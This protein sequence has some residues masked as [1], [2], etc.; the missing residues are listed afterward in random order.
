M[1]ATTIVLTCVSAA[2]AASALWLGLQLSEE[3]ARS[4]TLSAELKALRHLADYR[5]PEPIVTPPLSSIPPPQPAASA[6]QSKVAAQVEINP[7]VMPPGTRARDFGEA[8]RQLLGNPEYRKALQ[9]QQRLMVEQYYRDLPKVLGLSPEKASQVFDL[10]TNSSVQNFDG[11]ERRLV[12]Q[13]DGSQIWVD[14]QRAGEDAAMSKLI[15]AEG[16]QQ[17]QHYRESMMSRDEVRTLGAELIG[18][19]D[20]LREDQMQPLFDVIYAEQKRLQQEWN[21]LTE[22]GVEAA[23]LGAKRSEA[24]IAA[25]ERIVES[26]SSV[27]SG[28]QLAALKELYRRQKAQMESQDEMNRLTSEAMAKTTPGRTD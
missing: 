5:P 21:Q 27:L 13:S 20:P 7:G 4:E 24:A 9:T 11:R 18:S 12:T 8:R 2:G 16:M 14:Q 15:G 23:R 3:R 19:S 25:N 26:A 1:R 6:A 17:L 28:T 22:S 10:L